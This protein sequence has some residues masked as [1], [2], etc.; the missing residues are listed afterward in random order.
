M[1]SFKYDAWLKIDSVGVENIITN[2]QKVEII[3][4]NS[5]FY[6]H[7]QIGKRDN[8]IFMRIKKRAINHIQK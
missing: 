5:E 3:I 4:Y 8:L 6:T 1:Q 7:K 2:S